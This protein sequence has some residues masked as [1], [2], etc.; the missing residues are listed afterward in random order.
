[1]AKMNEEMAEFHERLERVE[2]AR[3]E[4]ITLRRMSGNPEA[5]SKEGGVPASELW[6]GSSP[7]YPPF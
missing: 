2:Q 5:L 3:L 4:S 6:S 7:N 1:M